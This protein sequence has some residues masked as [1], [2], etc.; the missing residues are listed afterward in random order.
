MKFWLMRLLQGIVFNLY[1]GGPDPNT[2]QAPGPA[3]W[4]G[5]KGGSVAQIG[6]A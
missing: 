2:Y 5:A 4:S 6:N 1:V 3:V